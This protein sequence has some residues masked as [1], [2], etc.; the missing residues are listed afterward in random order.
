MN[1]EGLQ[2]AVLERPLVRWHL[3]DRRLRSQTLVASARTA[4]VARRGA[5]FG[6]MI[7]GAI[8]VDYEANQGTE[9]RGRRPVKL[10]GHQLAEKSRKRDPL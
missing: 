5:E 9:R 10:G 7:D 4:Y 6:V 2:V 8:R 1:S 3:R